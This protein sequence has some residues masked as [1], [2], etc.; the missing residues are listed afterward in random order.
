MF[1]K[2][3]LIGIIAVLFVFALCPFVFAQE[4][5]TIT[6][7][8]PSPSGV[9]KIMQMY[10]ISASARPNPCLEGQMY[11]DKDKHVLYI[12][13]QNNTWSPVPGEGAN[14]WTLEDAYLHTTNNTD[15][16]VGIGTSAPT[17]KLHVYTASASAGDNTARFQ[18]PTIG[19]NSSHVHWGTT[20][21]WYIRSAASTGK[22]IMQ[23]SGG[24]VGIGVTDPDTKLDVYGI[25]IRTAGGAAP[26]ADQALLAADAFGH[27]KWGNVVVDS[28]PIFAMSVVRYTWGTDL[29]WS[30]TS[31]NISAKEVCAKYGMKCLRGSDP[32]GATGF[33]NCC[34]RKGEAFWNTRKGGAVCYDKRNN[35]DWPDFD[36]AASWDDADPG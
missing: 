3:K 36:C 24:A 17:A 12:C 34:R 13:G 15:W 11:Y 14:Y 22:V 6:T 35:P 10:P 5:L 18:A 9:Y 1:E 29:N 8:Y 32:G 21:D 4:K 25:R 19:P 33:I 20:G 28:A 30:G 26:V 23:D 2:A 16:N 31:Y 7:Y 27:T